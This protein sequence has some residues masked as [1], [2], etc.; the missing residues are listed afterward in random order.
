MQR[1]RV[2]E[3]RDGPGAAGDQRAALGDVPEWAADDV[4]DKAFASWAPGPPLDAPSAELEM[5]E[6]AEAAVGHPH[7]PSRPVPAGAGPTAWVSDRDDVLPRR[8]VG[9]LRRRG[10]RLL[11]RR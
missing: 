7:E 5:A 9:V 3:E 6:L 11:R 4:L 8:R 1:W 2:L 10:A